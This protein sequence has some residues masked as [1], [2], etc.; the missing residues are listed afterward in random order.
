MKKKSAGGQK[1]SNERA[2]DLAKAEKR[3]ARVEAHAYEQRKKILR[4]IRTGKIKLRKLKSRNKGT[5]SLNPSF[6]GPP[7]IRREHVKIDEFTTA[8][9]KEK[10]YKLDGD[11]GWLE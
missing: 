7:K 1:R 10:L 2:R 5:F 6:S 11:P 3:K 4:D 9:P 8:K